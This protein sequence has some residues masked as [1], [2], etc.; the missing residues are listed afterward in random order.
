[1]G[2]DYTP[3]QEGD[4]LSSSVLK[5]KMDAI[6]AAFDDI[7]PED[8]ELEGLVESHVPGLGASDVFTAG[9]EGYS[10]QVVTAMD[11]YQNGLPAAGAPLRHTYQTFSTVGANLPYGDGGASVQGGWKILAYNNVVA[12][13]AEVRIA[14]PDTLTAWG[15]A[16]VLCRGSVHIQNQNIISTVDMVQNTDRPGFAIAIGFE[17][18]LGNRYVIERSVRHFDIWSMRMGT[19]TTSTLLTQADVNAGDNDLAAVFLVLAGSTANTANAA[20]A[21]ANNGVQ[22]RHYNLTAIPIHAGSL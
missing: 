12:D 11:T 7:L 4:D 13:A 17:D 18:T 9:Y 8:I 16:G 20:L 22:P 2:V 19:A 10:P 5:T 6:A 1:M 3:V 14:T 21:G 15:L